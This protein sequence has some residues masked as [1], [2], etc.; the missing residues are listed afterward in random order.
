[1]SDQNLP[2]NSK[3]SM[4]TLKIL[5]EFQLSQSSNN[6]ENTNLAIKNL[7]D[8]IESL[9]RSI[10]SNPRASTRRLR[11]LEAEENMLSQELVRKNRIIMDFNGCKNN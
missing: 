8:H 11:D 4:H 7:S 10:N 2:Q 3:I 6:L 9:K 5:H 1:M